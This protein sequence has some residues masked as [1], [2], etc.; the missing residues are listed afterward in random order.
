MGIKARKPTTPSQRWT[1]LQDSKELQP[2][3]KKPEKSLTKRL[4][5]KGGRNVHGH[6]TMR[7]RGGG[8][9]R[10]YRIIDFKRD[11]DNVPAAV[12][13]I[14]YDPNRSANIALLEY[15]DGLRQYIVAPLGLKVGDMVVSGES[16]E[17]KTGNSMPIEK[18]SAGMPIHNIELKPGGGAKICRGAGLEAAIMAH[19][20]NYAHVR[21]PSGEIRLINKRC[22]ATIGQIGNVQHERKSLGKAGRSRR[23]GRRPKT[24]GVA[25]NPHDHPLGGGEGKSSGGRHPTTPWGQPTKGFRTRKKKK[26]SDKY[27]I[28]RRPSKRKKK[29]RRD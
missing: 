23:M 27:I 22:R 19:E 6:I 8:H 13:S 9:K 10:K 4:K 24:R 5:K 25:M 7:H 29:K 11:K 21:L 3:S 2:K 12:K 26:Y 16:V 20:G 1:K 14:E 28:K 18:I 15:E 17:M